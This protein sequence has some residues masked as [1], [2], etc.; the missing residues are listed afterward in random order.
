[1]RKITTNLEVENARIAFRNFS[2]KEGKFNRAGSRNFSVIFDRETGER[3]IDDGWNLRM[4]RPRDEDDEPDYALSV[5]VQYNNFPPHIYMFSGRN[6]VELDEESVN[7]LDYADI[8]NV[9]LVIR[10]YNWE[11]N[12]KCGVKAYLHEMYVTVKED[13]FGAKYRNWGEEEFPEFGEG[14][15]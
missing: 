6:K 8:I 7:T 15:F 3:L 10:P 5:A 2:G 12:G 1:M 4:L 14:S 13:R 9:D 11:V